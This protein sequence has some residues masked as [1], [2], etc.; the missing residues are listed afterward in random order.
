MLPMT[1]RKPV[2]DFDGGLVSETELDS[3]L[4]H[5]HVHMSDLC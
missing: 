3:H 2:E 5:E 4:I 1:L